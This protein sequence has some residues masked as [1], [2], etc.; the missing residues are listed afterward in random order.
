[1]K[2]EFQARF[3]ENVGGETPLRDSTMSNYFVGL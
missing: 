3:R 2:R 1:V